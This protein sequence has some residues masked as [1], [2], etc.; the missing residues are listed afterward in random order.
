MDGTMDRGALS[1]YVDGL[2][3]RGRYSFTLGE[4]RSAFAGSEPAL[5]A[6]LYRLV[7]KGLASAVRRGFYVV[8]P[9]E[10][11]S[12]G[13]LPPVLFVDDLMRSLG[14]AYYAGLLS[15]A[16]LHGAGHEQ[17]QEFHVVSGLPS[18]RTLSA[19]SA[20]VRFFCRR[21]MPAMGI[22]E[23]NT[24][25]GVIRVSCP[26]LTA[27]DLVLFCRRVG[28]VDRVTEVLG[29][30]VDLMRPETLAR[31]AGLAG[32]V[33]VVQRLGFLLEHVVGRRELCEPLHAFL[34]RGAYFPVALS[35]GGVAPAQRNRW[36]VLASS[37]VETDS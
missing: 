8:V 17:P 5:R 19:R 14:R 27:M 2:Q 1:R 28:G 21:H 16:A 10:Y 13:V 37:G 12:R 24:D 34:R 22:D 25:T 6:A 26:E 11:R 20:R 30:L 23:K 33:S 31:L 3:A 4:A 29:D 35:S 32:P 18:L 9:P 7:S 15:A 36:K